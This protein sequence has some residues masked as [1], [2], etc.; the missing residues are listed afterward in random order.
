MPFNLK[1][2]LRYYTF[3]KLD[4]HNITHGVF[5]RMGGVSPEPWK[6]LNTGGNLGDEPFNVHE[7]HRRI[8]NAMGVSGQNLYDVWQVHSDRI[9]T[10]NAPRGMNPHQ[11]ADGILC[12]VPGISLLMRFADCVPI[13]LYDPQKRVVGA[14][15][16]GW[17]GTALRI[18]GKAVV[19]MQLQYSCDPGDLIACIGPSIGVCHYEVGQDVVEA[20]SS[21]PGSQ[22]DSIFT[23]EGGTMHLDLWKA[24]ELALKDAGVKL[25]ETAGICTACNTG[26]WY[27][28][29]AEH[30]STGRFAAAI[31]L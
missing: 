7:N 4:E 16:A 8:L 15:H 25:V 3:S 31:V 1:D 6:S 10:A 12:N 21:F 27:S 30:G 14:V 26:E 19:E 20:F 13:L 22:K 5:T 29:R 18:A 28:H 23:S 11:K 24:N 17:K 9:V 2:G